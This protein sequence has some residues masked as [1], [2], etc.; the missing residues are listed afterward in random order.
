MKNW[1]KKHKWKILILLLIIAVLAA[2]FWYGGNAPG[3]R[4]WKPE[5]PSESQSEAS[6]GDTTPATEESSVAPSTEIAS[7]EAPSSEPDTSASEEPT[8]PTKDRY[9]TDPVPEDKPKPVEPEEAT[10]DTTTTQTCTLSITCGTI[11]NNMDLC[12]PDKVG[13]VPSNGVIL[14]TTTCSFSAGESV[15]DLLQRICREYGIHL[16][17]S[18]TPAYNSAYVEGIANLYEFDVGS[19]SGWMYKVNGW[20]PNYG[21]SRYEIQPGDEICFVYTC[22]Y[23][24]DVGGSVG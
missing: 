9:Q 17:A 7:S 23:G 8:E 16:E 21:C 20:F 6:S 19:G 24:K 12:D 13:I 22:N 3:A 11:L 10:V 15:F 4:G 2:A 1:L 5:T 14:A 18:W